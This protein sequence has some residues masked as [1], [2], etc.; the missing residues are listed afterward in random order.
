[1]ANKGKVL[2]GK[3]VMLEDKRKYVVLERVEKDDKRNFCLAV[4]A[5]KKVEQN[6]QLLEL[7]RMGGGEVGLEQY[8]GD[9]AVKIASDILNI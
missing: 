3:E 8:E 5:G 9:D 1:M 2:P 7:K 6:I 4:T